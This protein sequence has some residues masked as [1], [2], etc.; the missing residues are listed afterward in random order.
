MQYTAID[1]Y[2]TFA[3]RSSRVR[4]P[5]HDGSPRLHGMD[6]ARGATI[7]GARLPQ[8]PIEIEEREHHSSLRRRARHQSQA[9]KRVM[10]YVNCSWLL[11]DG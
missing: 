6:Q 7:L 5:M 3:C 1:D 10:R 11:I 2:W 4:R 8:L 9:N